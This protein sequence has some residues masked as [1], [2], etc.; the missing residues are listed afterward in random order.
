MVFVPTLVSSQTAPALRVTAPVNVIVRAVVP[1]A[2]KLILPVMVVAPSI[3][4]VR[5]M[6]MVP[7]LLTVKAPKTRVP[8]LM[9]SLAPLFTVTEPAA[10]CVIEVVILTDPVPVV[11]II[12]VSP[13]A[14]ATPP[15]HVE[16]VDQVPPV[17]VLVIVAACTPN[18]ES[19]KSR[20]VILFFEK[21]PLSVLGLD[22]LFF[23]KF[24]K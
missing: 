13:V 7:P 1:V 24:R 6:V 2:P 18:A 20:L 4:V 3:V 16:P 9:V 22:S 15:T 17:A 11:A 14:G 8:E 21:E 23:K 12:T 10:V 19:S 5:L